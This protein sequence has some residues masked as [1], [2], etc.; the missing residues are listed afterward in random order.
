MK[1]VVVIAGVALTLVACANCN[2]LPTFQE[3]QDCRAPRI[4]FL[5]A[6]AGAAASYNTY[7]N[8]V[9]TPYGTYAYHST[10]WGANCR[11]TVTKTR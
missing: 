7:D 2:E 11:T 4:A 1:N 9:S 8:R 6:L 5:H 3:Q 10:C